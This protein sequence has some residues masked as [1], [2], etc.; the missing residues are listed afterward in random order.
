MNGQVVPDGVGA[1]EKG[2]E[3]REEMREGRGER[4]KVVEDVQ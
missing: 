1:R 3:E 4:G 2:R